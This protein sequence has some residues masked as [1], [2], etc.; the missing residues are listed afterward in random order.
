MCVTRNG[1]VSVY[2]TGLL[3]YPPTG[4]FPGSGE[5]G[6]TGIVVEPTTGDLFVTMLYALTTGDNTQLRP[7]IV[8]MHSTDGGHTM[9]TQT[10]LISFPDEPQGQS[11]QISNIT[12]GPDGKL[13][14]HMG[15]GFN[16]DQGPGPHL[17]WRQDPPSELR[18]LLPFGQPLLQRR[19]RADPHRP[20]AGST[21][22]A[23]PSAARG[24]T[25]TPAAPSTSLSRTAPPTTAS[26]WACAAQNYLYDGSDQSMAN[27]NIIGIST[28]PLVSTWYPAHGPV[29]GAFIQD[30]DLQRLGLPRE[31]MD[32]LFV[33]ESGPTYG[34]GPQ[35]LGKRVSE[36][37][38]TPDTGTLISGPSPLVEYTGSGFS[39]CVGIAAG[40]DGLYFTELYK[41]LQ[42]RRPKRPRRQHLPHPLRRRHRAPAPP[43]PPTSTA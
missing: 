36:F 6:V 14:V 22:S 17:R 39:S 4:I 16:Q 5:C 37:V 20:G 35:T 29:N 2:A 19:R 13:Y 43:A 27:Y 31:K 40:P 11:H 8:R 33:T 21:G 10:T 1:T 15:D 23:T 25:A 42:H 30:R 32:H 28:N 18:R 41:D 9:A 26:P 7:K 12:I 34:Q 24:A 3:N 38:L